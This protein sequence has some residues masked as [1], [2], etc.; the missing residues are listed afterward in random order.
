MNSFLFL[1]I[2]LLSFQTSSFFGRSLLSLCR[3]FKLVSFTDHLW[4]T[5][6]LPSFLTTLS[7]LTVYLTIR[8]LN[9]IENYTGQSS[10]MVS[11]VQ[12]YMLFTPDGPAYKYIC[13]LR[14]RPSG[15]PAGSSFLTHFFTKIFVN[16]A[17]VINFGFWI[18]FWFCCL[19][20]FVSF[21]EYLHYYQPFLK[22][23]IARHTYSLHFF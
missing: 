17:V 23:Q 13:Y 16:S 14:A 4:Y 2:I 1:V 15:V 7:S 12:I 19:L 11:G 20:N 5:V 18:S 9:L 3:L 22:R 21:S 6:I 8:R 10:V